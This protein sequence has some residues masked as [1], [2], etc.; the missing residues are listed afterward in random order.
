MKQFFIEF[1]IEPFTDGV[2]Q[3][4]LGVVIWL[5]SLFLL[6]GILCALILIVDT[7]YVE[8][9]ESQGLIVSKNYTPSHTE[10]RHV[11]SGKVLIPTTYYVNEEYSI[12]IDIDGL[13]DNIAISRE[14]WA[15][16]KV[17]DTF[18]FKNRIGRLTGKLYIISFC[19]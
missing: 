1:Y 3:F 12:T 2:I 9:K 15:T 11:M 5:F 7:S 13:R 14:L 18:C 16:I 6:G 10:T 4:I 17:L 19:N 8:P